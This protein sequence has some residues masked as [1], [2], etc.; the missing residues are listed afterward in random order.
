MSEQDT[1]EVLRVAV[2]VARNHYKLFHDEKWG[3]RLTKWE[4]ALHSVASS[5]EQDTR[6]AEPHP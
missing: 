1:R 3:S 5:V 6:E 2:Q 4:A